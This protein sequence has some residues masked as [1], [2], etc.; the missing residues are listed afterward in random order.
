MRMLNKSKLDNALSKVLENS[1]A[2]YERSKQVLDKSWRKITA[3]A[4][5][6]NALSPTVKE[7]VEYSKWSDARSINKKKSEEDKEKE[8]TKLNDK[9]S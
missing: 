9:S 1:H 8:V 4:L 2:S 6:P 5:H 7:K 3:K